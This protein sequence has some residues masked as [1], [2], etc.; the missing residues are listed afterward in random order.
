MKMDIEGGEYNALLGARNMLRAHA[1]G[2]IFIELT[3]W[4]ANRSG[5]STVDVK[6]I[7]FDAGY[8]VYRFCAWKLTR[9]SDG[10]YP[11]W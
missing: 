7:L 2:L 9:S 6:R 3:E 8:H 10:R 5:Y 4:A 1:I 11:Q